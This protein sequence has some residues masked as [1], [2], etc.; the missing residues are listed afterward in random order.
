MALMT[1]LR[2]GVDPRRDDVRLEAA[3][4]H[5]SAVGP[6][7]RP[8]LRARL[9]RLDQ[10]RAGD[11]VLGQHGLRAAGARPRPAG[12]QADRLRHGHQDA[13]R[14]LPGGVAR[15]PDDRRLPA[16]DGR[17]LRDDRLR[18]LPQ[19]ARPRS[20][21]SPTPTASRSSRRASGQAHQGVLGRRHRRGD[22]DPPGEHPA[23]HRH[24]RRNIGCPAGGKTGTTDSFNDAWFVGFTP[25]ADH[26]GVGR[27]PERADRDEDPVPRRPGGGRARSRPRSGTTT[28]RRSRASSAATSRRPRSRSTPRRSSA[29]TRAAAARARATDDQQSGGSQFYSPTTPTTPTTPA[30]DTGKKPDTRQRQR[31]RQGQVQPGSLR[32]APAGRSHHPRQQ[33]RR[34]RPGR[35]HGR[36][37]RLIPARPLV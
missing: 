23:G 1:A 37:Q 29:S 4:V 31:Q 33:R 13:P 20:P 9:S 12:G 36:A 28:C 25:Q 14:R 8:D 10:P 27:L 17:R 7:R 26:R 34:Q 32:V 11:A 30:P 3:Q 35:R 19:P 21:R 24:A 22:A 5:R 16:R 15:R 18:R 2:K 6:D